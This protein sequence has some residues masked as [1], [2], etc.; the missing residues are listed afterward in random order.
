LALGLLVVCTGCPAISNLPAPGRI[1]NLREPEFNRE[2]H[3]YVPAGYHEG[4]AWPL[5]VTCHG[6]R[7]FDTAPAQLDEWKG[8]AERVGF[9]LAAP[10]LTGT[11]GLPPK[12]SEQIARQVDDEKAILSMVASIR[13]SRR[14]DDARVFLTG[15]S[16]GGYA[17]LF[18][19]LRNPGVFRALSVRQGNFKPEYVE[20][21]VPF[22]DRNQPIQIMYG[23]FDF[24]KDDAKECIAW[25]QSHDLD[26]TVIERGSAHRRDP[27]PVYQFFVDVVR[28]RPW[29]RVEVKEDPA[30]DMK[31][32]FSARSSFEPQQY[33]WDFGDGQRSPVAAP[34][35]RYG[36]PGQYTVRVALWTS[37]DRRY[38]RQIELQV[39]RV[40]LGTAPAQN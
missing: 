20:P 19:G 18:T 28:H 34:E 21:C 13:A 35:H 5:V 7:P 40:R 31:V 26:P 38:V 2:Y 37:G 23:T 30:D 29:I 25:L 39:P 27:E 11:S 22:L 3:L 16:A 24:L 17:V 10:E 4:R 36:K 6:T 32:T 33:L 8:L 9:L 14:V 15:W 12:V 1:E